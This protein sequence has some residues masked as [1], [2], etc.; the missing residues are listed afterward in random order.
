MWSPE[1]GPERTVYCPIACLIAAVIASRVTGEL[2]AY[3]ANKAFPW[4]QNCRYF[5]ERDILEGLVSGREGFQV[6][7]QDLALCLLVV[8]QISWTSLS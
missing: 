4:Q 5:L 2:K 8:K 3:L 1:A 7:S 6:N